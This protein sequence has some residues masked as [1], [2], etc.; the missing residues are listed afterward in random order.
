MGIAVDYEDGTL[1]CTLAPR[2]LAVVHLDGVDLSNEDGLPQ[3]EYVS[4]GA[5]PSS[6]CIAPLPASI[7]WPV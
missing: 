1:Y 7:P 3:Y 4:V 2:S 6:I 5:G